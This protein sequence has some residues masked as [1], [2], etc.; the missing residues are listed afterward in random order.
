MLN[1]RFNKLTTLLLSTS[2]KIIKTQCKK[3][4]I[5]HNFISNLVVTSLA[6]LKH[7]LWDKKICLSWHTRHLNITWND[8]VV[9]WT[10]KVKCK[11]QLTQKYL[12]SDSQPAEVHDNTAIGKHMS[13]AGRR[14]KF[15]SFI[16]PMS[17]GGTSDVSHNVVDMRRIRLDVL[18]VQQPSRPLS[19]VK[20]QQMFF[21]RPTDRVGPRTPFNARSARLRKLRRAPA[22]GLRRCRGR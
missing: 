7:V 6:Y 13:Q 16:M 5:L 8:S 4:K 17:I 19:G 20:I 21:H 11:Q 15:T 2:Y 14:L 10:T 22:V 12:S 1:G 9:Y 18:N 3:P